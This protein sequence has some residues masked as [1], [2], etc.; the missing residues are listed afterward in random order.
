MEL[1]ALRAGR[2]VDSISRRRK[3]YAERRRLTEKEI[4]KYQKAQTHRT[5][6]K[7]NSPLYY[8]RSI[9]DRVRFLVPERNRLT[10]SL[11]ETATLQ[12]PTSLSALRDIV[13]LCEKD[14]EVEF[15]PGLEPDK[16]YCSNLVR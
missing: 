15:R 6:Q 8:H 11:F 4:R 13:A 1:T 12:S 10:S 3:L 5:G 14:S 9:F 2:D 16:Y 7:D